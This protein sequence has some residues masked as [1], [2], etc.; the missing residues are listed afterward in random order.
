MFE[1]VTDCFVSK[2]YFGYM[3]D[4]GFLGGKIGSY[5]VL[6]AF[7]D[8]WICKDISSLEV[9]LNNTRLVDCDGHGMIDLQHPKYMKQYIHQSEAERTVYIYIQ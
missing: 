5:S 7:H 2:V 3:F 8:D 1:P 4:K 9:F 6:P